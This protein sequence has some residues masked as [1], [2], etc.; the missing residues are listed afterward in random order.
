VAASQAIN[1]AVVTAIAA[2]EA[3]R[4]VGGLIGTADAGRAFV[5]R[6]LAV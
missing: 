1:A 3:T 6:L 4:D 5:R 2:G